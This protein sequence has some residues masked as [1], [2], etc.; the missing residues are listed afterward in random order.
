MSKKFVRPNTNSTEPAEENLQNKSV[1]TLAGMNVVRCNY[2]SCEGVGYIGV[3]LRTLAE[4]RSGKPLIVRRKFSCG[5]RL[6]V[7][8]DNG[9][10]Y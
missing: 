10:S 8:M 6:S 9:G 4:I 7:K 1:Y 5:H 3:D 2:S